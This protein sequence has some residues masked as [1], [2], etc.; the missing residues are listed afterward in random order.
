MTARLC[1]PRVAF[2]DRLLVNWRPRRAPS[3][4]PIA[5]PR[6]VVASRSLE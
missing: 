6:A 2:K 4:K 1:Q 5:E 3:L